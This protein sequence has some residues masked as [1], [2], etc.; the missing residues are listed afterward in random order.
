VY[1]LVFAPIF[2]SRIWGGRG[3]ERV[4]GKR[5]PPG[6]R[7]GESWEIADLE[8][9][10]SVVVSGPAG[11]RTIR[12]LVE[13][14]GADLV[15]RAPLCSG[16]FPLLIKFLDAAEPLSIQ[17]H[18]GPETVGRLGGAASKHEAWYV[19]RAEPGAYIYRGLRPGIGRGELQAAIAAGR[20][21]SVLNRIPVKAGHAFYLPGGTIHA[22]GGGTTVAEVQ[23]PSDVTYRLFDW[24]RIDPAT[25]RPRDLHVEEALQCLSVDAIPVAAERREHVASVW[26]AVTSLIRCDCF[27]MERVRMVEGVVQDIPYQ[28]MVIWMVL[29]GRGSITYDGPGSPFSFATGDTV[30]LPAALR[31]GRVQTLAPCVWLEVTV[32]IRSSLAGWQ[33]PIRE[34]AMLPEAGTVPLTIGG[35][36][37]PPGGSGR[38]DDA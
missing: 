29:E 37:P 5:L 35:R 12:E 13:E 22:L 34:R 31:T 17:V 19:V 18:P 28:E 3:L 15:G 27:V 36:I 23:T 24:D 11:G 8:G 4:L 14:W 1:P 33:R 7:I 25:D 6:G 2:K 30:L 9:Q 20:V 21:E 16:R 38:G 10:E 26:T 32:P